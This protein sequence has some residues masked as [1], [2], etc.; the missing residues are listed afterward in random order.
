MAHLE[1]EEFKKYLPAET[2][3]IQYGVISVFPFWFWRGRVIVTF[4]SR[5]YIR[6]L[7]WR[8]W[9]K[10]ANEDARIFGEWISDELGKMD[11]KEVRKW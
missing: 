7:K 3:Q 8:I 11:F 10:K 4:D 9:K 1:L 6:L 5:S 2:I